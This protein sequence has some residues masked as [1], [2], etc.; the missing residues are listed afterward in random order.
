MRVFRFSVLLLLFYLV[1]LNP[2]NL[3][4]GSLD[5]F[6]GSIKNDSSDISVDSN[7][8]KTINP[9]DCDDNSIEIDCIGLYILESIFK[10]MFYGGFESLARVNSSM[11]TQLSY[12]RKAEDEATNKLGL[13]KKRSPQVPYVRLDTSYQYVN[14]NINAY[15]YRVALGYGPL[16]FH[17]NKIRF[18]ES[19]PVDTLDLSQLYITYRMSFGSALEIDIGMGKLSVNGND[20]SNLSYVTIPVRI[21]P[22]GAIGVEFKPAWSGNIS[23]YDLG[24]FYH[25]QYA[26][27]KAGYRSLSTN[28]QS[29]R[30]PYVGVTAFY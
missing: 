4:A 10:A 2:Q 6:E 14:S 3:I 23:D 19:N 12:D 22:P 20:R 17:Y 25:F 26:S 16:A 13:R 8:T 11:N 9:G 21:H 7:N 18:L 24:V 27:V 30:G 5:S 1:T 28:T 29:L 15:D